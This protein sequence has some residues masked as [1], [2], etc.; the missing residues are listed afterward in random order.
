MEGG[1]KNLIVCMTK[2]QLN[3][4]ADISLGCVCIQ[5]VQAW[6]RATLCLMPGG[7]L[8]SHLKML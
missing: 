1:E 8:K 3:G 2:W 7:A 5:G 6:I 4:V